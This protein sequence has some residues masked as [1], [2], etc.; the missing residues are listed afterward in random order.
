MEPPEAFSEELRQL[1]KKRTKELKKMGERSVSRFQPAGA[2]IL[3]AW[4][5][6]YRRHRFPGGR[7]Q[8]QPCH[9]RTRARTR[10]RSR[11]PREARIESGHPGA[12]P[13]Y[14][15]KRLP[16]F[17]PASADSPTGTPHPSPGSPAHTSAQS[18]TGSPAPAHNRGLRSRR[19]PA[20]PGRA[21]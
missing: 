16:R 6:C 17:I 3:F 20:V 4:I 5:L 15:R 1:E 21:S 11:R 13:V 18:T 10:W 7:L 12:E 2:A 14:C 19:P 9:S 8:V